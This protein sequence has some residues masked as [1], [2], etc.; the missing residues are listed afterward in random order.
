MHVCALLLSVCL[1]VSLS[2]VRACFTCCPY[3]VTQVLS[4]YQEE[5][6]TAESFDEMIDVLG[7]STTH[8]HCCCSGSV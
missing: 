8:R 4:V 7:T 3:Y 6:L 2:V 1:S 5:L